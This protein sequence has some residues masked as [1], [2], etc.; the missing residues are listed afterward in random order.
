MF[1]CSAHPR[2]VIV[3]KLLLCLK[4]S[5]LKELV[6]ME[7]P[8][9]KK[10]D[11]KYIEIMAQGEKPRA[12]KEYMNDNHIS[13]AAAKKYIDDL[14]ESNKEY[15]YQRIEELCER[16]QAAAAQES[17]KGYYIYRSKSTRNFNANYLRRALLLVVLVFIVLPYFDETLPFIDMVFIGL[18]CMMFIGL[19]MAKMRI[20]SLKTLSV[21]KDGIVYDTG[22]KYS[23]FDWDE[24]EK[25][26]YEFD[27]KN[28]NHKLVVISKSC[29]R[30]RFSLKYMDCDIVALQ[31]AVDKG[32]EEYEKRKA[33]ARE[34]LS[35][36][37]IDANDYKYIEMIKNGNHMLAIKAYKTDKG[38]SL[39]EA[40]EHIDAL[41]G[42][43]KGKSHYTEFSYILPILGIVIVFISIHLIVKAFGWL[44]ALVIKLLI[45]FSQWLEVVFG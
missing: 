25:C 35:G 15:L 43:G 44:L 22:F 20:D 19:Y 37:N 30:H 27:P 16:E 10:S 21:T 12:I 17:I 32:F 38:C 11:E 42:N 6:V 7:Y 45:D 8:N 23:S 14:Y 34:K 5:L 36:D 28:E 29:K 33:E 3:K 1:H 31:K 9:V 18:A 26:D 4:K 39:G 2:L 24:M 40:K 13:L 41:S